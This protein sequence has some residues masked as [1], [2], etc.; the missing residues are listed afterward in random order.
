[1][2]R[3]DNHEGH[4]GAEEVNPHKKVPLVIYLSYH[5]KHVSV[6]ELRLTMLYIM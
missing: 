5:V 6:L 1:M 4:E 3:A 2:Y